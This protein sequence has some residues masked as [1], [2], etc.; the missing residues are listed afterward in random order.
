MSLKQKIIDKVESLA[1]KLAQY[2]WLDLSI[3]FIAFLILYIIQK[4]KSKRARE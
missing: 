4:Y 3:A 1:Q 2:W